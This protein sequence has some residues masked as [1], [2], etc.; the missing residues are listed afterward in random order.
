MSCKESLI[1]M[2]CSTYA[3]LTSFP[4]PGLISGDAYRTDL[5]LHNKH[6][7]SLYLVELTVGIDSNLRA[8]SGCSL[9]KYRSLV[10]SLSPSLANVKFAVSMRALGVLGKSCEL[11]T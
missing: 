5:A 6:R 9:T 1:L 10:A 7:K 3:D 11:I 8:K 4:S 2:D